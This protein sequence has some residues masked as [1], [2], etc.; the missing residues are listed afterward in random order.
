[1]LC[2][3]ATFCTGQIINIYIKNSSGP[4]YDPYGTPQFT[5]AILMYVHLLYS[6]A[7]DPVMIAF[8]KSIN[9]TDEKNPL[10]R[11]N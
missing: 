1:M 2:V 4:R 11:Q 10:S 6:I 8:F 9:T 7:Y 3:L 5:F